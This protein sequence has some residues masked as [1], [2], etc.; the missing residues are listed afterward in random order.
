MDKKYRLSFKAKDCINSIKERI[1]NAQTSIDIEIFYFIEDRIGLDFLSLLITKSK[2]GLKIRLLCDHVGSYDLVG[3]KTL[4]ILK[5]HNIKVLF[6]NSLFPFSKNRKTIWYFRNHRRTIIIDNEYIFTGSVCLGEP[7]SDWIELGIFIKDTD[8]AHRAQIIFN[9]T[10]NK[11]YHP[12]FNIG[13]VSQHD[14]KAK[15]DFNYITQAPLQFRRH[16]YKHYLKS[17]K[18]AK[19][20]IY[21]ISPYFIP[22][23]KFVRY[24]IDASKRHV[25]VHIIVPKKT[26]W[27]IIDLAR[28]T[29]LHNLLKHNI[30]IYFHEKMVHSKFA[31]FDNKEAFIGTM[32]LDNLSLTY[33]YE[34]GIKVL[35]PD[36]ISGLY[37][38][39]KNDLL[40]HSVKLDLESWNNRGL[41]MKIL[42][43]FVWIIRRFL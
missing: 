5:R 28:N 18:N 9:Q 42:E 26:E 39:T 8:L 36:C 23:G 25:R 27:M 7:T 22:N 11:V 38:H 10:W 29:H 1:A 24:L 15:N 32:N 21:L 40:S 13:S 17:I 43:R 35:D 6:F 4:E 16:I 12:T 30:N 19:D 34:N 41:L 14:L 20:D 33:N 3:S 2:E 31:I 37:K